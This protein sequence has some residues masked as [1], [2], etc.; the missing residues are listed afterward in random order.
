[1]KNNQ[2]RKISEFSRM[3]LAHN[4]RYYRKEKDISQSKLAEIAGISF[5]AVQEIEASRGNPTL[6]TIS[7]LAKSFRITTTRLLNLNFLRLPTTE[8]T[9]VKNYKQ[10]FKNTEIAVGLRNLDGKVL[11]ANQRLQEIHGGI[12]FESGTVDVLSIYSK[13]TRGILKTQLNAER[14]GHVCPYTIFHNN[15]K[16]GDQYY[17]R[18]HPTLI[19]NKTGSSALF[20]SIY[21]SEIDR[22]CEENYFNYVGHLFSC[23]NK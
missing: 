12:D 6:D 5:R 4:L 13:E 10:E 22:D 21:L 19:L 7:A 15:S 16:N 14:R 20:T 18:C 8:A 17:L 11:W 9:F 23:V 1:M 2:I 3:T